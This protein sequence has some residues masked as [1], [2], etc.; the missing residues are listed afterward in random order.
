[1]NRRSFYP[2][3]SDINPEIT[4]KLMIMVVI[5]N[6]LINRSSKKIVCKYIVL[7]L[8]SNI[9]AFRFTSEYGW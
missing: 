9:L 3:Y 6:E 1:M 4:Y 7:F 2:D 8:I 5:T